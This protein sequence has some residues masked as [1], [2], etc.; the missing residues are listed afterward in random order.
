MPTRRNVLYSPLP[1]EDRD[2]LRFTY[3]PKAH[4]K[5]PWKSIAL[6]LFLLLIGISLLSL[7]YFIFT[8]HMEGDD[9]QAYGLLFLGALAFLPGMSPQSDSLILYY[10]SILCLSA[11]NEA[12]LVSWK[13]LNV[14]LLLVVKYLSYVLFVN[15]NF[16]L[17]GCVI[18][19]LRLLI[20]FAGYYETRVAYHSWRGAPGYTFASIPD[21]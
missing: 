3:T 5:I 13:N 17:N 2:N 4:R 19:T 9:S 1:T 18:F 14:Y 21:Y 10:L 8:S 15:S 20:C 16:G 7:S 11:T 12:E 6:A